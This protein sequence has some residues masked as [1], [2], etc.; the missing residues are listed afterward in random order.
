MQVTKVAKGRSGC[1][2]VGRLASGLAKS[3]FD[4]EAPNDVYLEKCLVGNFEKCLVGN[5][6]INGGCL[7]YI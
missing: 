3:L 2:C 7:M 4:F 1:L 6:L 5:V